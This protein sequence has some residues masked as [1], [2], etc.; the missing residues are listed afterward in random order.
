MMSFLLRALS[1]FWPIRIWKGHGAHGPLELVWEQGRLVVNSARANQAFGSLH[2]VWQRALRE[3]DVAKRRPMNAL[4]LGF[5]AGSVAHI[6]RGEVGLD[7]PITGV[8]N[9]S[10]MLELARTHFQADRIGNLTLHAADAFTF[11]R[12][13]DRTFDLVVV[14]LFNDLDFAEGVESAAFVNDLRRIRSRTG[15]V[16]INTVAYNASSSA[17]SARLGHEL[18]LHFKD[19][20]EMCYEE[21]NRV[22]IA[23]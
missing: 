22:F 2:R 21:I 20:Q 9:D 11:A 14:D 10:A 1:W 6:L 19:V 23:L 16:L 18:R 12:Q 7:L 5:G 13:I 17:R 8:D 3:A 15:I 4:V